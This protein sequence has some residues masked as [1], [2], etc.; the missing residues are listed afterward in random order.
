MNQNKN[1]N[2][3]II[4]LIGNLSSQCNESSNIVL[5]AIS[6]GISSGISQGIALGNISFTFQDVIALATMFK[7]RDDIPLHLIDG[8][9]PKALNSGQENTSLPIQN[10]EGIIAEAL[11]NPDSHDLSHDSLGLPSSVH[12]F[13]VTAEKFLAHEHTVSLRVSKNADDKNAENSCFSIVSDGSKEYQSAS[14]TVHPSRKRLINC[15]SE[16]DS[17]SKPPHCRPRIESSPTPKCIDSLNELSDYISLYSN[18]VS[19]TVLMAH[20]KLAKNKGK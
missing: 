7:P 1:H 9:M 18:S 11:V 8:L 3:D 6:Q 5:H 2:K 16:N 19:E 17:S 14:S 10:K 15:I 4:Q 20:N 13:D 12:V